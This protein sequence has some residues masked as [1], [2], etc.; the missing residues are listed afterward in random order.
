MEDVWVSPSSRTPE[1]DAKEHRAAHI[2]AQ[3]KADIV[4]PSGVVR[5]VNREVLPH[6]QGRHGGGHQGT[7]HHAG[8]E[9]GNPRGAVEPGRRPAMA[10]TQEHS[11]QNQDGDFDRHFLDPR[12]GDTNWG[13]VWLR[14]FHAELLFQKIAAKQAD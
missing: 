11:Q 4:G 10:Q 13:L 1:G 12:A 6:Q 5:R 9:A 7:F 8:V 14:R 2:D 3:K